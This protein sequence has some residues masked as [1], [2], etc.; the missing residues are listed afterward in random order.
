MSPDANYS[1]L[2]GPSGKQ[3]TLSSVRLP[4]LEFCNGIL[5]HME[6]RYP[7]SGIHADFARKEPTEQLSGPL[8]EKGLQRMT[9]GRNHYAVGRAFLFAA[10][11]ID[12]SLG[13]PEEVRLDSTER[14]L[15]CDVE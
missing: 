12:N 15:H 1:H 7:V 9:E 3:K 10:A 13:F 4:L 8:T 6:E 11:I 2:G 14:V 5:A